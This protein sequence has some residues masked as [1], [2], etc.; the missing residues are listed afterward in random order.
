MG[1]EGL[2]QSR[3][4]AD[5]DAFERQHVLLRLDA[6]GR[7]EAAELAAG[8]EHAV[9]RNDQRHRIA[10]HRDADFLRDLG[11]VRA[12]APGE[13]AIGHGLAEF[14]LAQ[15]II[16]HAPRRIDGAKIKSDCRKVDLLAG[17]VSCGLIDDFRDV[18]RQRGRFALAVEL[19]FGGLAGGVGQAEARD[20]VI[21]PRD[22]AKA[23]LGFET[24]MMLHGLAV[25][26]FSCLPSYLRPA[27]NSTTRFQSASLIMLPPASLSSHPC[28]VA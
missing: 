17:K 13:L 22:A 20:T 27:V 11:G 12:G 18:W 26:L 14:D 24:V 2:Q 8:R 7:R 16:D 21:A 25:R 23:E 1:L 6:S 28:L 15:R 9:A 3:L 5:V 4:V 10:R 19:S